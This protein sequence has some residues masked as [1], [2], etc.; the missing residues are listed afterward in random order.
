MG[1]RDVTQTVTTS[2]AIGDLTQTIALRGPRDQSSYFRYE[3]DAFTA[4][5]D[6]EEADPS[7][8]ARA[9]GI[10][11]TAA[12]AGVAALALLL[13]R[14]GR[15]VAV[16]RATAVGSFVPVGPGL[17]EFRVTGDVRPGHVG[18]VADERVD[19]IDIT[20]TLLDLAV[21]GHLL[22]TEQP[23]R[24][25]AVLDWSLEVTGDGAGL[26][27][28]EA[29]LLA[30]IGPE[31]L[32]VCRLPQQ[33]A[34][35]RRAL[36]DALYDEMPPG[37]ELEVISSLLPYT[38]VLGGKQRWLAALVAADRDAEEPDP[39]TLSWYHAPGTWHLQDLPA[40]LTQF[41]HTVQGALYSR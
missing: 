13:G 15:D 7:T 25:H 26:G 32:L 14:A 11:V 2:A 1:R 4:T 30:A 39:T 41:T 23:R 9:S 3:V 12:V 20:A 6:G 18:T 5:V 19:P 37:R 27:P 38:V 31:P 35:R 8:T 33:L 10:E 21:R 24:E 29:E 22:I 17:S 16:H 34:G 36:Q 40:S 28:F